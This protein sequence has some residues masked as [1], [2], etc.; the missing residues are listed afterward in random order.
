MKI[1]LVYPPFTEIYGKYKPAAKIAAIYPPLGLLYIA[2]VLQD[3][4]KVKILDME[5]DNLSANDFKKVLSSFKPDVV[6][7][8]STTPLHHQVIKLFEIAKNKDS[9]IIT[10]AGGPHP[11]SLPEETLQECKA[12]DF[13]VIGEGEVTIQELLKNLTKNKNFSHIEGIAYRN[14]DKVI[15]TQKRP[16]IEN[17]D[18]L[19]FPARN[20][21]KNE[22]YIWGVP[23]RGLIRTTVFQTLRGCPYQC[24]FCSQHV[25]FGR[26]VRNRSVEN[27]IAEIKEIV[28]KYRIQH[29]VLCDDT[30]GL[31]K[32][33]TFDFCERLKEANLG[34]TWEGMTRVNIVTRELLEEMKSAGFVRISFGVESGNQ[35][36]LDAVK[37]GITLEQIKNAY[38]IA[39]SLGLETRM[40][41]IF[42]LPFETKKTIRKTLDFMK[43]LKAYQAYINIGTPFPA[44]EYYD[45]TKSGYGG[46]K[47]L[48][49]DWQEYRRWGNAVISVNDLSRDDLIKLQKK[50]LLEFYFRPKQIIYNLKR[51]GVK[52]AIENLLGFGKSFFSPKKID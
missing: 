24:S 14:K 34:I 31:E 29:L 23:G 8:T 13:I 26:K 1:L 44:T 9:K 5:V 43:S 48:T 6:G 3:K 10:I 16:L 40:S 42:G 50:G 46:M 21:I 28:K 35:K 22:K 51:A 36:I 33:R 37:K 30:F 20:L 7:I 39:D 47:L 52:A 18:S 2:A 41:I 17:L 12:I 32:K 11:T 25:L 15:I 38:E 49:N 45:M 4:H 27:V 19:P